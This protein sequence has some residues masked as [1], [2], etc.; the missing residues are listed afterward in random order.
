MW[1]VEAVMPLAASGA[2]R[3]PEQDA[4]PAQYMPSAPFAA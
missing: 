1:A 2:T 4:E 3:W